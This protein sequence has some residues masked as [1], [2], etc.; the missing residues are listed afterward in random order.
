MPFTFSHPALILPATYLPKKYYSLTGLIVGS[1]T[2]DFEYFIRMRDYARYSHT[3]SGMFWFDMPLGLI[4]MFL[5]HN[6]VRNTLIEHLPFSINIRLSGFEKFNWNQYFKKNTFVVLLSLLVGIASHLFLDSFTHDGEFFAG[7]IP[8]LSSQYYILNH[9]ISGAAICQY[10]LS[11]VGGIIM[12]IYVFSFPEGRNTKQDNILN[13]WLIVLLITFMVLAIRLYLDS[14]LK[15][16]EH[17]DVIVTTI[18]GMLMGIISLSFFL[19]ENNKRMLYKRIN[20]LRQAE[21]VDK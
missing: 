19:K 17:E 3:V 13:F 9:Q 5:F 11:L 8:F 7:L 4:I 16:F 2:P 10:A 14:V 20:K 12:V 21:R 1:M 6:V 18:S 15:E